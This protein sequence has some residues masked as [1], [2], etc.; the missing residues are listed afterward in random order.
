MDNLFNIVLSSAVT[1]ALVKGIEQNQV[2]KLNMITSKRG[3]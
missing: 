1:A 2:N 3:D